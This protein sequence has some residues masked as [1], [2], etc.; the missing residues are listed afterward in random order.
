M[1]PARPKVEPDLRAG[2]LPAAT[3]LRAC[4]S[5]NR[6]QS[7]GIKLTANEFHQPVK[8][9]STPSAA[10]LRWMFQGAADRS[11][12]K[13]RLRSAGPKRQSV[14]PISR[15]TPLG[16]KH[17]D[18]A[19]FPSVLS[20]LQGGARPPGG[21]IGARTENLPGGQ[22]PPC[23]YCIVPVR[24]SSFDESIS[25]SPSV[26]NFCHPERAKE[27]IRSIAAPLIFVTVDPSRCSG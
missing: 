21:L 7:K 8:L 19:G 13:T 14:T 15:H 24:D 23:S 6:T 9:L 17:A 5:G 4:D 12:D 18:E 25:G 26:L 22:V 27:S 3:G 1:G 11:L 2:F 10:R 20:A 16:R